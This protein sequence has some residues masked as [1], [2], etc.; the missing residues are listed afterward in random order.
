MSNPISEGLAQH[1]DTRYA[2]Q[3]K[4]VS[5]PVSEGL[6]QHH[7]TQYA[8]Q[9]EIAKVVSDPVSEGLAQHHGARPAGQLKIAKLPVNPLQ[10]SSL[11]IAQ[12]LAKHGII[13]ASEKFNKTVAHKVRT[14]IEERTKNTP[15]YQ[16]Q[17]VMKDKQF[18]EDYEEFKANVATEIVDE[19]QA[20]GD[21]SFRPTAY[22]NFEMDRKLQ[23][24]IQEHLE[25][26]KET[27]K[28]DDEYEAYKAALF[29]AQLGAPEDIVT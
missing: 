28:Y 10:A 24:Y 21:A 22:E 6:A 9:P 7:H 1:H 20:P 8:G 14:C 16:I 18:D 4:I 19:A 27:K 23:V 29:E 11:S 13:A 3:P 2:G 15:A 26:A 17:A 5:N 12:G 25:E